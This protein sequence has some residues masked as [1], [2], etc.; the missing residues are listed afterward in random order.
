MKFKMEE[1]S[2]RYPSNVYK[3]ANSRLL[4]SM[5][6]DG[7]THLTCGSNLGPTGVLDCKGCSEKWN[8]YLV[9]HDVEE[10]LRGES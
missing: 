8:H 2:K 7:L 6:V 5:H 9:T 4:Q 1:Y 3:R 10:V